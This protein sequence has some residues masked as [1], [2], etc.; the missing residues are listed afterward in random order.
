MIDN[1]Q[2]KKKK[3]PTY[4]LIVKNLSRVTAN[5]HFFKDGL[6]AMHLVCCCSLPVWSR[7]SLKKGTPRDLF[8]PCPG[9]APGRIWP[10]NNTC[11]GRWVL[12]SYQVSLTSMKRFCSKGLLCVPI[13][14][15]ALVHP[16]PFFHL[17]KY[18]ENSLKFIKHLNLLHKHSS[19]YKHVNYTKQ[20]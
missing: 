20:M 14:I 5:Q 3:I 1:F 4:L 7:S 16:P 11:K 13:H 10:N 18:I 17:N 2:K 6:I 8:W 12:Y 9:S 19:T 15:H